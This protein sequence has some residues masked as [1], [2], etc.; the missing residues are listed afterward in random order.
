M[1]ANQHYVLNG[2]WA[3]DQPGAFEAA[4]TQWHYTR[5][6]NGHETLEA[7]GPTSEDLFVMVRRKITVF[8]PF[9]KGHLWTLNAG[10]EGQ[11]TQ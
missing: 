9:K 6:A 8:S 5:T 7:A 4:G 3:V 1:K 11:T 10:W 2:E